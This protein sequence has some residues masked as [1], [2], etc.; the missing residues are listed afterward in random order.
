MHVFLRSLP[1]YLTDN[2]TFTC[3][4][5]R[6]PS[7]KRN[8]H[9]RSPKTNVHMMRV[10]IAC[11]SWNIRKQMDMSTRNHM[12]RVLRSPGRSNVQPMPARLPTSPSSCPPARPPYVNPHHG[13]PVDVSSARIPH[14]IDPPY[15]WY[16]W[17][18]PS[19]TGKRGTTTLV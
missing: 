18:K 7:R 1:K 8:L 17:E 19:I 2:L 6:R 9:G 13:A 10:C 16:K 11:V 12:Q 4:S 15:L 5:P 3:S 14:S